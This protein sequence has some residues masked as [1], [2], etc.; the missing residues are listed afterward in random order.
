MVK[1][2]MSALLAIVVGVALLPALMD[3]IED[4]EIRTTTEDFT[5]QEDDSTE[6]TFDL[7]HDIENSDNV[8]VEVEGESLSSDD[9]TTDTDSVTLDESA[10]D[11]DDD[12]SITYDY[13]DEHD[14]V[15]A[16]LIDLLPVLFT[17][18]IVAGGVSYIRFRQ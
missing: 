11:T 4:S 18:L 9:F 10:S 6:E 7:E 16:S 8:S 17:V 12:V 1:S 3:S 2:L 13:L 14:T 15:V 5:A